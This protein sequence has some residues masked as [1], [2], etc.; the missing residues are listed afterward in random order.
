[1]KYLFFAIMLSMTMVVKAQ[2]MGTIVVNSD[3]TATLQFEDVV[4][5]VVIGN[6]PQIT[7]DKFKY[8]DMFQN[9]KTVVLRGN[10]AESPLTSIT[11]KLKNGKIWYGKLK[12]GV[13]D[14]VKVFYD[15]TKE[16]AQKI[17]VQ[18]KNDSIQ[19]VKK[20]TQISDK[21]GFV[22]TQ[23]QEYSDLG[24]E[25]NNLSVQ[26]TN[27]MNDDRYT[28]LKILFQNKSGSDYNIDD[29][30]FKYVEGKKKGIKRTESKVEERITTVYE[31]SDKVVKAY[32][33]SE[34][35]YVIPLFTVGNE[36]NL[37]I[38]FLE[39]N[40]TRNMKIE[41]EAKVMSKV[42]VINN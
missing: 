31:P 17:Q 20:E 26:V 8:Y 7:A 38:Q 15:F 12:Y 30:I 4:E 21:L 13:G 9:G 42:K 14:D 27:I 34:L 22:M 40:G 24:D 39:K 1:M 2:E 18:R 23:E 33:Q 29:I 10:D 35:G 5:F 3:F 28:Y 41:I 16:V 6:N 25:K 32:S 37:L 19:Q 36:G 11:V